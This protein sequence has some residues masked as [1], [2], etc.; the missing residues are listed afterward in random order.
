MKTDDFMGVLNEID[1]AYV[2]EA[3]YEVDD[4]AFRSVQ[5]RRKRRKRYIYAC[6]TTATACVVITMVVCLY[7]LQYVR[8]GADS[9]SESIMGEMQ[10]EG[11]HENLTE[12]ACEDV[13]ES[14]V[15][16]RIVWQ[17]DEMLSAQMEQ[18]LEGATKEEEENKIA[19]YT[20]TQRPNLY[21]CQPSIINGQEIYL[22]ADADNQILAAFYERNE[23][24]YL[25]VAKDMEREE[26]VEEK[27]KSVQDK[28]P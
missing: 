3:A 5:A 4:S 16:E 10:T 11:I 15:S 9:L 21:D 12:E 7:S 27:L 26:F 8:I 17:E 24:F 13:K 6:I 1:P 19:V 2:K 25:I 14:C 18:W 28:N 20:L 22:I 23:K